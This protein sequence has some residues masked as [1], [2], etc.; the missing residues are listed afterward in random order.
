MIYIIDAYNTIH[1]IKILEALLMKSLRSA[2]DELVRRA[3]R[4]ASSRGDISKIILV[5]DGKSEFQNIPQ[6]NLPKMEL[7]FSDTGEG[8]DERIGLILERLSKQAK[9][10][11]VSDDNCVRNHARVY[12][13]HVVA[14][15]EFARLLNPESKIKR[16]GRANQENSRGLPPEIVRDITEAYRKHL[17]L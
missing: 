1:K 17:G 4:L 3:S 9:K 12:G 8:A 14:V 6:M 5:F 7:V 2:R 13:A 11:V 15:S 16:T 10:C